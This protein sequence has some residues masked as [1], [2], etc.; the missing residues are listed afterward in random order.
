[1]C[2]PVYSFDSIKI[3]F[4]ISLL[5]L[6]LFIVLMFLRL[7]T[8]FSNPSDCVVLTCSSSCLKAWS[9]AWSEPSGAWHVTGEHG[10][11]RPSWTMAVS[12]ALIVLKTSVVRSQRA[13]ALDLCRAQHT[14]SHVPHLQPRPSWLAIPSRFT[15][16]KQLVC[17]QE[18]LSNSNTGQTLN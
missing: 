7:Y 13:A 8:S 9:G 11:L 2:T 4:L 16:H 3:T 12:V 18:S 1:M 15:M 17:A 10:S 6:L 14:V 5:F